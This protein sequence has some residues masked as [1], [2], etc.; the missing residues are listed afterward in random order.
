MPEG[1]G[2]GTFRRGRLGRRHRGAVHTRSGRGADP[3]CHASRGH[4]VWA[5]ECCCP[6]P[7]LPDRP[8][9]QQSR[10]LSTSR[11]GRGWEIQKPLSWLLRVPCRSWASLRGVGEEEVLQKLIRLEDLLPRWPG[12]PAAESGLAAR[13]WPRFLA[14]SPLPTWQLASPPTPP[15]QERTRTIQSWMAPRV[16]SA[17]PIGDTGQSLA[18]WGAT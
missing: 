5:Q 10:T 14:P 11:S 8:A 1:G 18:G 17:D 7:K 13:R 16:I 15:W 12:R 9:L 2:R 4:G 3:S 6:A